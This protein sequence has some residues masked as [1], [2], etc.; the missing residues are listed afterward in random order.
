MIS[1]T[2]DSAGGLVICRATGRFG[3]LRLSDY[4]QALLGDPSFDHRLNALVIA[5]HAATIPPFH[6]VRFLNP[7]IDAWIADRGPSKWA[8]V[9]PNRTARA[10]A[11]TVLKLLS[12]SQVEARCFVS[13]DKAR[14]WLIGRSRAASSTML[15][16]VAAG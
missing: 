7:L 16:A 3:I 6:M 15:T 13:E 9:L 5:E 10:M 4:L 14:E 1:H 12:L 8:F 11:E 2:I